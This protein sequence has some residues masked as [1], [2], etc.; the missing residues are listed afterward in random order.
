MVE[1]IF[2]FLLVFV[3]LVSSVDIHSEILSTVTMMTEPTTT[4]ESFTVDE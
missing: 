2:L 3:F 4:A 1:L